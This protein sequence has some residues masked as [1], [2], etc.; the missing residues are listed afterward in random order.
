MRR[1]RPKRRPGRALLALGATVALNLLLLLTLARLGATPQ[2]APVKVVSALSVA[3]PLPPPPPPPDAPPP[4]EPSEAQAAEA[5]PPS[6]AMPPLDL[7]P[8]SPSAT[9]LEMPPLDPKAPL[10]S[11]PALVMPQA[12]ARPAS[13]KAGGGQPARLEYAPDLD[14][15]YPQAARAR[16]VEGKTRLKLRLDARGT[17]TDVKIVSSDPPGVFNAAALAAARRLRYAPATR[18]GEGVATTI[19]ITFKWK[20]R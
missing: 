14:G 19:K 7:A 5:L 4:P 2:R 10:G 3:P 9:A 15:F 1:P 8:I 20:L 12:V 16:R 18:G 6:P 11:L 17:I 13:L